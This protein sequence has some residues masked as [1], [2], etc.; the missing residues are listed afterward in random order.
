MML[1]F[2]FWCTRS[3]PR[4]TEVAASCSCGSPSGM[5]QDYCTTVDS[6]AGLTPSIM[7][8]YLRSGYLESYEHGYSYCRYKS[9]PYGAG[10]SK[11]LGC[12]TV[13]DGTYTWPEGLAHYV[14]QHGLIL[15]LAFQQHIAA[16][17]SVDLSCANGV[18]LG[19][20]GGQV[21]GGPIDIP[22]GTRA[23]LANY[24]TLSFI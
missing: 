3:C 6:P 10:P 24:C 9:C 18:I 17:L 16:R 14:Q 2:G 13:T 22:P 8:N 21:A 12:S 5:P 4:L 15:P 11:E 23:W 1:E 7:C 19:M 20:W